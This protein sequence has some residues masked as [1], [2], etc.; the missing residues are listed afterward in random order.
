MFSLT[1]GNGVRALTTRLKRM[2]TNKNNK[3]ERDEL[4]EGFARLQVG[5]NEEEVDKI[6]H[7]FDVNDDDH[8]SINEFIRG[9]RVSP[10]H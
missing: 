4:I 8:I 9:I 3:L 10:G 7:Y 2:D 1:G 6:M 5:V